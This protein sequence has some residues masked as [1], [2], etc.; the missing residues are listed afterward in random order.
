MNDFKQ[1]ITAIEQVHQRLQAQAAGAV[2]RALTLRNWLIGYYIVEFEQKGYER[3]TYGQQLLE[4]IAATVTI[5]GISATNLRLFRQFYIVYPQIRQTMSDELKLLLY[6]E[7]Q[8]IAIRQTVSDELQAPSPAVQNS[9]PSSSTPVAL[10]PEKIISR[11]SFSHLV[12][13][14]KIEDP[15]KRCF[16]EIECIKG[17]WGVRELKRQINTLYFERSGLS[18]QPEKLSRLVQEKIKPQTPVDIVKNIYAFEFLNIR[19]N[20]VLEESDLETALLD[21]LQAFITE[22]GNGFCF[23]AR[24][25]RILIGD[26]YY[27]IDLVFYHRILKCHVLIE[28]KIGAFEH[29]DIGQLNTYLNYFKQEIS[30]LEDNHPV[31]ILLVAEKDQ[32][33]VKYATA[34]MD[35]NLFIQK[36]L[37]R[38][39]D[40]EQLEHHIEK[41]LKKL[42]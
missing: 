5:N 39:P 19:L 33:L 22:L 18:A 36:Y 29:G 2:N 30:E 4:K 15:L 21:N 26:T 27:F 23:E 25:K 41:E 10:P 14:T 32:A 31:G 13:L 24:Q 42:Q 28:L 35:E 11:L 8:N 38:L 17:T 37:I 3:A 9:H 6:T 12:E 40:K 16:Y 20:P 34:G 7:N 1:L